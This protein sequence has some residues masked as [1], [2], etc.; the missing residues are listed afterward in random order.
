MI[1]NI[2]YNE[3]K[4]PI[5]WDITGETEEEKRIV[6]TIR[7]LQFFGL[8]DTVINYNGRTGGDERHAGTLHWTQKKYQ[9]K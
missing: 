2:K 4:Q 9:K 8:D 6:N 1:I 5:G 7:N 3:D